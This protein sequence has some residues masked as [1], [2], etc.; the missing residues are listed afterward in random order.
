MF[1]RLALVRGLVRPVISS[2]L[3]LVAELQDGSVLV[4][5]HLMTGKQVAPLESPIQRL[6]LSRRKKN[7]EAVYPQIRN[8]INNIISSAQLI[9]YPVGS[10]YSSLIANLLPGGVTRAIADNDCPKIY[11]PNMGKDPEAVGLS[12]QQQ[13]AILLDYLRAQS[14]APR[15]RLLNF[16]A[17]DSKNGEYPGGLDLERLAE[18]GV[19]IIDTE[20]V[21]SDSA[22]YTD[23]D[24]V[25]G[26]LLSLT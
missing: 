20:L 6:Y 16:V 21:S 25:L 9:C 7:P 4:G 10:F 13:T 18:T 15:E 3:H 24:L 5:Q 19:E 26:V 22:P 17:V 1:S 2:D 8:K 11:I 14:E 12:V 23:P